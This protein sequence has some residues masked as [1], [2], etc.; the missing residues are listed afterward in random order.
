[1]WPFTRR[2][3]FG[4]LRHLTGEAQQTAKGVRAVLFVYLLPRRLYSSVRLQLR[5]SPE[6]SDDV[7]ETLHKPELLD[8]RGE[9][10]VDDRG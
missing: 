3:S 6:A 7:P 5:Q 8:G 4:L 10:H 1:M 2:T 9:A